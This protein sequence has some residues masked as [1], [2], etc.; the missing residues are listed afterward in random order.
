MSEI[1]HLYGQ[2]TIEKLRELAKKEKAGL[3][4]YNVSAFPLMA[5][6]MY[7]QQ[8]DDQ[9]DIWFFSGKNSEH[10]ANILQDGR[11]QFFSSNTGDSA[12]FSLSGYAEIV[13]DRQKAEEL[14]TPMAKIW[15]QEGV[16]DPN[17]SL[18]RLRPNM[19]Y[20]WDTKTNRMIEFL[21]M[22]SSVVTGKTTDDAV[23]GKL[24]VV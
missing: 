14:W 1:K 4:V 12:Y 10:N 24:V 18:V 22:A 3:L 5:C 9:G 21:K 8:V 15:F 20:Y 23:Q 19:G 6:P 7:I 16:D 17:L 11:V 2:A 13:D